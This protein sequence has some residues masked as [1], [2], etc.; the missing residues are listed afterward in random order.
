[1]GETMKSILIVDDSTTMRRMVMA[2]LRQLRDIKFNEAGSGLEA[3]ERLALGRVDLI[4][5]DLNMPDIHGLEVLRF[6]RKHPSFQA[7]PVMILTT[8]GDE[9]SRS[10]AYSNGATSYL[11]KPFDPPALAQHVQKLLD[12]A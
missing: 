9:G 1:M 3:I 12:G 7:V 2:S 8:R 11:T 5:L 6:V 4:I 10:E